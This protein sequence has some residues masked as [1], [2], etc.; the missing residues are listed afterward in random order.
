V[1]DLD[2]GA[3]V[4]VALH[5]HGDEPADARRWAAEVAPAGWEVV[6][7]GAPV[8]DGVRSWFSTGPRGVDARELDDAVRRVGDVAAR[9]R[10]A[11]RPVVLAGFSQGAAVALAAAAG[12]AEVNGVVALCGFWPDAGQDLAAPDGDAPPPV[13]LLAG[14]RDEVVPAVLSEDAAAALGAAGWVVQAR[15]L[16]CAHAVEPAMADEARAFVEHAAALAERPGLR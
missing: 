4:L 1:V 8:R 5:G 14:G 3:G 13:L 15:T 11:G 9:I 7:P 12:G 16:P 6:A 2:V 10:R